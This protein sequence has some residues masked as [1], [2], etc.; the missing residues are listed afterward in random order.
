MHFG[1]TLP[2]YE[3]LLEF[4][5]REEAKRLKKAGKGTKQSPATRK[6]TGK[7]PIVSDEELALLVRSKPVKQ[8][9]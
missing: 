9:V 2:Q 1:Q 5:N 4:E 3:T 8:P 6:L 7:S